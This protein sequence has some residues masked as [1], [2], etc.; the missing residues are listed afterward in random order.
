MDAESRLSNTAR[1]SYRMAVTAVGVFWLFAATMA[2]FAGTTLIWQHTFLARAWGLNPH[3]W[4]MLAPIGNIAGPLFLA[5]SA[6][7]LTTA[8]LWFRRHLCGWRLAIA[9][10][11]T[12]VAGDLVNLMRGDYRRGGTGVVIAGVLLYFLLRPQMRPNFE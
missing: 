4:R 6:L 2:A 8:I 10:L 7:L 3:A 9:I 1:G 11:L 12:Q 5:F